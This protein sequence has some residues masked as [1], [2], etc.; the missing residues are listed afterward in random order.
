V[1]WGW[2]GGNVGVGATVGAVVWADG[3][4]GRHPASR[5][6]V[7]AKLR[8]RWNKENVDLRVAISGERWIEWFI[9]I[10]SRLQVAHDICFMRTIL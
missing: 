10:S 8:K 9:N 1:G 4:G 5:E 3:L 6:M 2:I 7:T